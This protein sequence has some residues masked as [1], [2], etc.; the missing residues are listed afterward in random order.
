MPE[1]PEV[2]TVCRMLASKVVGNSIRSVNVVRRDLRWLVQADFEDRCQGQVVISVFR[3]GKYI[4]LE[5]DH[6]H[7]IWHL[8]MSGSITV[9]GGSGQKKHDH[10]T[11]F[12]S[13]GNCL[14]YN[15]PRR[16]GSVFW[17]DDWRCH[18]RIAV[19]GFEPLCKET[20]AVNLYKGLRGKSKAIKEAIMDARL[21]VGVGNIYANEA[22]FL[23]GVRPDVSAKSLSLT[24]VELLLANIRLVL[25]KAIAKGGTTLNDYVNLDGKPGYF[26]QEL[27]VYGRGGQLCN[28]CGSQLEKME[29][30]SRQTVYCP[31]C[32]L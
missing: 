19:L 30:F 7:I 13:D 14:V 22:L 1:L 26:Q 28:K 2:E 9:Q 27:N 5:L 21:M 17:S 24:Q 25:D 16:F 10:L 11:V 32:Q 29:R 6:G 3:R 8:G 15:D 12:L 23:S 31:S 18:P 4:I 20:T